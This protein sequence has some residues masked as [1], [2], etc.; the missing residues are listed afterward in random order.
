MTP[1]MRAAE[2]MGTPVEVPRLPPSTPSLARGV[3]GLARRWTGQTRCHEVHQSLFR[4]DR[5][6][7]TY[8]DARN[9]EKVRGARRRIDIKTRTVEQ[10]W[11]VRVF[12]SDGV[13]QARVGDVCEE[14]VEG[15]RAIVAHQSAK[16][17][18]FPDLI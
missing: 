12:L 6:H 18:F 5:A 9:E 16:A 15:L 8:L 1:A 2:V 13:G 7:T 10:V 4:S 17:H 3:T 11:L 14:D